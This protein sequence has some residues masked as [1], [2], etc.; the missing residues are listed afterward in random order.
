MGKFAEEKIDDRRLP[1]GFG[2]GSKRRSAFSQGSVDDANE[3]D[4]ESS[5]AGRKLKAVIDIP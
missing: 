2:N 4:G 5:V 3:A 1:K